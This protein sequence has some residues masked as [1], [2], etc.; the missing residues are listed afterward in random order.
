MKKGDKAK[1]TLNQLE[2]W[3]Q[4]RFEPY[5]QGQPL[6]EVFFKEKWE[7]QRKQGHVS[8]QKAAIEWL[9]GLPSV[10]SMPFTYH[11]IADV[12]LYDWKITEDEE[13]AYDVDYQHT[14]Y[15]TKLGLIVSRLFNKWEEK[16]D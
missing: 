14:Y 3:L 13:Q 2:A 1:I 6:A 12:L 16:Q 11:D 5:E 9:Q 10:L 7:W 4:D 15:W 8:C